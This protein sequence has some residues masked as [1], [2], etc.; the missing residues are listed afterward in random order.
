MATGRPLA[1]KAMLQA[2]QPP[3]MPWRKDRPAGPGELEFHLASEPE[4]TRH[5]EKWR[6]SRAEKLLR[7]H[8][9]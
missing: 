4:A 7:R 8:G 9:Q 3:V 2:T 6:R 1:R 5:D